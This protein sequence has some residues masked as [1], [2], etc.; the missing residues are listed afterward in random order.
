M[1]PVFPGCY[2]NISFAMAN[3]C[4][5]ILFCATALFARIPTADA[6]SVIVLAIS[7]EQGVHQETYA[8]EYHNPAAAGSGTS[9]HM[10]ADVSQSAVEQ[11]AL[12]RCRSRGGI[13]PKVVLST[14][15]PGYFAIAVSGVG[16]E[17]GTKG[18]TFGTVGWSGPLP[19][20]EAAANEA[21]AKC[22][23]RGG[24][25]PRIRAQWRD[26]YHAGELKSK[27]VG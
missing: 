25:D 5:F 26:Y 12:K 17:K 23:E 3:R 13:N 27:N 2:R 15:K 4:I 10:S 9:H 8:Y 20:P 18:H 11:I 21:I 6:Y 22:K 24:T 16:T 19:S 14:G 7:E 1:M